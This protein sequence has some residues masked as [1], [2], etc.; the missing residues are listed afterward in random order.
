MTIR[1]RSNLLLLALV[2]LGAAAPLA[3]AVPRQATQQLVAGPS[4][5]KAPP[6][7]SIVAWHPDLP[8]TP[9]LPAAW[10]PCDG[11]FI[12]DPE[13]PYLG[14]VLPDLNGEARYLRGSIVSGVLQEDSTA[15]N[16]LAASTSNAGSHSHNVFTG[17]GH[18]HSRTNVGG[19]GSTRG[20]AAAADQSGTTSVST[21]GA[22]SHTMDFAGEH[23]HTVLLAGDAETRPVTMSVVWIMRIK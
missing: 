22:H 6:V 20:F 8:G 2:A 7:G 23:S 11:Q 18:S 3:L 19:I 16:G 9:A 15:V 17:G 13:S 14:Q 10:E 4:L 5:L 21:D 1:R 12:S